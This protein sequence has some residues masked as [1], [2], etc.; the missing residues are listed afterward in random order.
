MV[1]SC[2]F[3]IEKRKKEIHGAFIA[4]LFASSASGKDV[5]SSGSNARASGSKKRGTKGEARSGTGRRGGM[6]SVARF[7]KVFTGHGEAFLAEVVDKANGPVL[8]D[9]IS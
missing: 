5:A 3:D 2:C 8:S 7:T 6:G 9:I 4:S 1:F